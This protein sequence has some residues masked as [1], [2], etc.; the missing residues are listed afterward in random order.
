MYHE[1]QKENPEE[2]SERNVESMKGRWKRLSE[3]ENKWI[4]AYKEAYRR[5]RSGMR[6][7]DIEKEA[8]AIYEAGDNKFQDLIIFNDVM[9]KNP[10]RELKFDNDSTRFRDENQ[11][12]NK[13]SG[14]SSKRSRTSEDGEYSMHCTSSHVIY[15]Y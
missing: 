10:K 4:V 7:S 8:H 5:K 1:V 15:T 3:N 9:C 14:G 2:I 11:Q 13:E 12:G 6:Q